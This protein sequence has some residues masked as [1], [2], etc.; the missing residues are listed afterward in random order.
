MPESALGRGLEALIQ[1]SQEEEEKNASK[2]NETKKKTTSKKKESKKK[3]T[4]K[5]TSKKDN[6]KLTPQFTLDVDKIDEI[7][8]EVRENPRISLW[9]LKSAAVFKYM[10][11]TI[12]EFSISNEA[13]LILDEAIAKKYPE[14]WEL[15]DDLE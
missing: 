9:S 3:S 4:Q 12:P 7:K 14:I 5:K 8:E 2:K 10:K 13:S 11:K 15:F 1:D 6:N